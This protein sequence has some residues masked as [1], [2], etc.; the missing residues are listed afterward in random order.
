MNLIDM[1]LNWN[2]YKGKQRD[3]ITDGSKELVKGT[4]NTTLRAAGNFAN[5]VEC[6]FLIV[7]KVNKLLSGPLVVYNKEKHMM[8]TLAPKEWLNNSAPL[9]IIFSL[10]TNEPVSAYFINAEE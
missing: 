4:K 3:T 7:K 8:L 6:E 9:C 1:I 5:E 2:N 10:E